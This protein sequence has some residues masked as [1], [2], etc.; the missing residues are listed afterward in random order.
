MTKGIQMILA[1]KDD[2]QRTNLEPDQ[3][4]DTRQMLGCGWAIRDVARHYGL[5]EADLR[6]QLERCRQLE[7]LQRWDGTRLEGQ[8]DGQ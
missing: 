4:I 5:S 7:A 6:L 2:D 1:R 3:I 8:T